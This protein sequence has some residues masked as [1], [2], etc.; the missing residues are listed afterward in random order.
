M[1]QRMDQAELAE[2]CEQDEHNHRPDRRVE[3]VRAQF[4]SDEESQN[5]TGATCDVAAA[6]RVEEPFEDFFR[7][8]HY[9]EHLD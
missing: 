2:V 4:A 7:V 5:D 1:Q 8:G 6:E 9:S 3:G